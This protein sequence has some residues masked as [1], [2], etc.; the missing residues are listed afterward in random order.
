MGESSDTVYIRNLCFEAI[1]GVLPDERIHPQPISINVK[2]TM[3]LAQAATSEDLEHTLDYAKLACDIQTLTVESQ[4]LLIE[5]LA[6]RVAQLT[7]QHPRAQTVTVDVAKPQ[8]VSAADA[9][10][11]CI[12]RSRG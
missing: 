9:V 5:T 1:I 11:V 3:D 10:G 12:T 2:V 7:L 8:A 4:C 6:E